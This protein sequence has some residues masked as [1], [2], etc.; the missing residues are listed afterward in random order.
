MAANP[1]LTLVRQIK[2]TPAKIY[3]ALTKPELLGRWWKPDAGPVLSATADVRPGGWFHIVFRT[4]DG[5]EQHNRGEYLEVVPNERLVFT[6]EW[7]SPRE[8]TSIVTIVL[9]SIA[10]GTELTLTHTHFRDETER[11]NYRDGWSGAFDNLEALLRPSS[12]SSR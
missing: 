6:W 9:R 1:D 8:R 7:E 3:A 10:D 5:E 12:T 2:A 11:D 4:R